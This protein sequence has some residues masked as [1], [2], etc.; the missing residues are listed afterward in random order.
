MMF[1][2]GEKVR[3]IHDVGSS[4]YD[5]NEIYISGSKGS[6]AKIL[7]PEEFLLLGHY[8]LLYKLSEIIAEMKKGVRYPVKYE[9]IMPLPNNATQ[10]FDMIDHRRV[11]GVDLIYA[12]DLEKAE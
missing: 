8:E 4:F 2:P 5:W 3:L 7:T 12:S 10:G 6:I 9:K 1:Q 11:G